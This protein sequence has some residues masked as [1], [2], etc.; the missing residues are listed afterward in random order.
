[1]KTKVRSS[2]VNTYYG[3]V[4]PEK[5]QAQQAQ[6]L[7]TMARFSGWVSRRQVA[8]AANMETSTV[9]ARVNAMVEAGILEQTESASY[10]CP[11]TGT[12]VIGIRV[13]QKLRMV[14]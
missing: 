9:A 2:S 6:I 3:V 12:H 1:M 13:A 7:K 8:R 10:K 5:M 11:I 4:L 14:A